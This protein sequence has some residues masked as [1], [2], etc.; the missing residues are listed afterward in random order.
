MTKNIKKWLLFSNCTV[1]VVAGLL[2][3]AAWSGTQFQPSTAALKA[4]IARYQAMSAQLD[5]KPTALSLVRTRQEIMHAGATRLRIVMVIAF[6]IAAL[7][8][9]NVF[10]LRKSAGDCDGG[11][12]A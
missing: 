5:W 12:L 11:S 10:C 9:S 2:F 4:E 3:S 6:G 7:A 1:L 8:T